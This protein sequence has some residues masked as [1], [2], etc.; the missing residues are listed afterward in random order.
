M[1]KHHFE[2]SL[3]GAA[4]DPNEGVITGVSIITSDVKAKGH[5]LEVDGKTLKQMQ[6]CAKSKGKVPV[7]W[8]H[9]TGADAVNGYL[10][11]FRIEGKKL[12]ADWHLLKSH[13]RFDHALEL[14]QEMPESVGLSAS[15][16]GVDELADGTK[17]Y[18][19]KP[20]DEI[21]TRYRLVAGEKIPVAPGTKV[22]ARCAELVSV[23][24]VA[25]PAANPDGLFE[26]QVDTSGMDMSNNGTN[27]DGAATKEF[28]LADVMAGITALTASNTELLERV[29]KLEQF[30]AD[31][32][33]AINGD[34]DDDD[35]DDQD[36]EDGDEDG[37]EGAPANFS[38]AA[39][40]VRYL[41]ARLNQ[42]EDE[43]ER[44]ANEHAFAVLEDNMAKLV[45]LN[46]ELV[47]QNAVMAEAIHLLQSHGNV[48]QFSAGTEGYEV[49]VQKT[50]T[51]KDPRSEFE[52]RQFELMAKEGK[53]ENEAILLAIKEDKARYEKHLQVI[54]VRSL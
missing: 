26:A 25:T 17:V 9:K 23:D 41:E 4:V 43:K 29:N 40:A 50:P 22:F 42:I 12:K 5:D 2:F 33:G 51:G 14:A 48:V 8:N 34:D 20:D 36:D 18:N 21:K 11:N 15:F 31:L 28:T 24:L 53:T 30:S 19:P 3:G 45:E 38:S 1:Q 49:T 44:A 16:M 47:A 10:T 13:E 32:E 39:G 27:P 54:G 35:A 52:A 46:Q 6:A 7:K 37:A